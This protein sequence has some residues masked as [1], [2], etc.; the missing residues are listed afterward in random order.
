MRLRC[1]VDFVVA[2]VVGGVVG[3]V[4]GVGGVV[5]VDLVVDLQEEKVVVAHL[6]V[7]A[8]IEHRPL[9]NSHRSP[10]SL[11]SL[12]HYVLYQH[13]FASSP[14]FQHPPHHYP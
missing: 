10:H 14:P 1:V 7:E 3:G 6:G 2:V 8:A 5:G 4:G 9:R 12:Q 11:H 13:Y